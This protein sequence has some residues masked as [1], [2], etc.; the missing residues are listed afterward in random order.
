MAI[1][2]HRHLQ[3]CGLSKLVNG[4]INKGRE[5]LRLHGD[6]PMSSGG[7]IRVRH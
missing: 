2:V 5:G 3:L 4:N 6:V 1:A 7:A